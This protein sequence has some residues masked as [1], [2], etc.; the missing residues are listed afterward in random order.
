MTLIPK[1]PALAVASAFSF[2]VQAQQA[3]LKS[4]S[5]APAVVEINGAGQYDPR[6]EDTASKI[7]INR[8]EII[9]YGDSN[10]LDVMKR[11]PG[12]TVTGA[13]GYGRGAEIRMRGLGN[14]Y[15]QVLID[16]DRPPAGFSLETINPAAVERIEILRSASAEFST[17]SIAGTINIVLKRAIST[18]T[19]EMK[20]GSGSG[21]NGT[22]TPA[23]N[24]LW[25]DKNGAFS[26][27]LGANLTSNRFDRVLPIQEEYYGASTYPVTVRALRNH[28]QGHF[29][30]L[31]FTPR[32]TWKLENG[33]TLSL[34][35][36]LNLARFRRHID[37]ATTVLEGAQP[38]FSAVNQNTGF[39]EKFIKSDLIW[40]HRFED[41][42]KLETKLGASYSK[43]ANSSEWVGFDQGGTFLKTSSTESDG[44]DKALSTSGKYSQSLGAG[45]ALASGWDAGYTNRHDSRTLRE[46]A[47]DGIPRDNSD[48]AYSA[49]V[50]RVAVFAQD[51]WTVTPQLSVYLGGRWEQISIRAS[52]AT[53]A[54]VTSTV[55]VLSP[56]LQILYK[57][58]DSKGDQLRFA[59]TQ[60][61]KAPGV[62]QILPYRVITVNNSALDP[63][64]SGNPALK[65]ER[66]LGFDA[67]YEHRLGFP[68]ALISL[69]TSMR[70][71]RDVTRQIVSLGADGRWI[72]LPVNQGTATARSLEI[73][74][75]MPLKAIWDNAPAVDF[76]TSYAR[77]WSVV[78]TV[79]GPH[80]RLA[81]QVPY[82]ANL[83]LDYKLSPLTLGGTFVLRGGGPLRIS[84]QQQRYQTVRRDLDLFALWKMSAQ[85]QI[86]AT[87]SFAQSWSVQNQYR[88]GLGLASVRTQIQPRSSSARVVWEHTF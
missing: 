7:V 40:S 65:P 49:G 79:P 45:H 82:S 78:D 17:Q 32:L 38:Q 54:G 12:V 46:Q 39:D 69:S 84:E 16:G 68:G 36:F 10:L 73:E 9:K 85:T 14:G 18:A 5:K 34:N 20:I 35:S 44:L 23:A 25:S 58:P 74:A 15:T 8:D 2:A 21:S 88:D 56:I 55:D 64:S 4:E 87:A 81:E 80:N 48:E 3:A 57:F 61:F 59:V 63:D 41:G 76:R 66:A 53:F 27:S 28:E 30:G 75:K 1:L 47:I 51:E 71:I 31:N 42:A 60:T 72:V 24:L 6:V 50:T 67:S 26:Y 22:R 29:D 33:D 77:N 13:A 52:G 86:R 43:N 11:L 37:I 83:G 62:R 19:K 70:K